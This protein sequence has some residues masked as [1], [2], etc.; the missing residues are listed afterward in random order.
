[1]AEDSHASKKEERRDRVGI[2]PLKDDY[3]WIVGSDLISF[4]LLCGI[5]RQFLNIILS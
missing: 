3:Q 1:M 4:H 5:L 2:V